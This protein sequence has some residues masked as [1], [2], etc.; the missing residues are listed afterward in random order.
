MKKLKNKKRDAQKK[1]LSHKSV[2][3]GV[4]HEAGRV[5]GGKDL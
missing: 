1:W 3:R 2:T 5:N 4:S